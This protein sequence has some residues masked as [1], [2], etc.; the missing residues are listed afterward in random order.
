MKIIRIIISFFDKEFF[1][2]EL[3]AELYLAKLIP[4]ISEL[5]GILE[6]GTR[7]ID[8]SKFAFKISPT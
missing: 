5:H 4:D 2:K 6:T 8:L 1:R 7:D 3:M